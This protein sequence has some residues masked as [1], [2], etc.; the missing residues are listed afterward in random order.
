[1]I[2]KYFFISIYLFL[3]ANKGYAQ[4]ENENIVQE[5]I[6]YTSGNTDWIPSLLNANANPLYNFMIYNGRIFSWNLRGE[7]GSVKIV[8]GIKWH[9]GI[10]QWSGD[11]LFTGMNYIFKKNE[12]HLNGAFSNNGYFNSNNTNILTTENVAQKK[13][14]TFLGNFSNTNKSNNTKNIAMHFN[15]VIAFKNVYSNFAIKLEE[16]PLGILPNGY[17][18]LANVFFS[19]DKK[20]NTNTNIGL[21]VLWNYSDQGRAATTSNEMYALSQ[22]RS[23]S[24]NWGWYHNKPYFP[25]TRQT[26][27]PVITFRYL[28]KWSNRTSLNVNNGIILG[29]EARSNLVWTNTADPRPDY[30]KYMPSY[31]VDTL[32]SNQLR[33]WYLQHPQQLQINFDQMDR[34]NN[35]TSEK[36]SFYIVNQENSSLLLLHGSIQFAHVVKQK[37]NF[38][39][40]IEYALDKVHF[41]NTIKDLLGGQFFFNYNGWMNDDTL[42]F[43]FQNDISQPNKKIKQGEKWGADYTM[44]SF[45]AKPWLQVQ[46][47][48]PVFETGFALGYGFEGIERMGSNQNGL[49]PNSKGKSGF[50]YF[51]TADMKAQLMYKYNGRIYFRS[52]LYAKWLAPKYQSVFIDPAINAYPSPYA[53]QESNYGADLSIFYRAPSFKTTLSIYQKFSFNETENKMFYH[54]A[55]AR[56]VYGVIGQI[57]SINNGVE[58]VIENNLLQSLKMNY[59]ATLSNNFY[60]NN[61]VYAYLDVNNLQTK[62]SG[63][64]QIKNLPKNNGPKL[65]NAIS[66]IYQPVYGFT[67]GVTTLYAQERPVSMN[68]FRRSEW[69]KNKIDPITW[70]QIQRITILDDQFVVNV[71]VSKYFQTKPSKYSQNLF[72]WSISASARN[73]LNTSIPIIAYEQ[74]RFD[75]LR[76]KKEKFVMKYLMDPGASFSIRIQL[77]IQ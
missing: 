51:T 18:K 61:P 50:Q 54:D 45:Q 9:S 37:V 1:M 29:K 7:S 3:I 40:G 38:Q 60:S 75:Y 76:F 27:V 56:F 66:L 49:Y 73:I 77:Q 16:A 15:N 36:R 17:K 53:L 59:A 47:Q 10:A 30:Y 69:V 23:Y 62:E 55:Y 20:A 41:F 13:T 65:V 33:D 24:P 5:E 52:I 28:K 22:Q 43:S 48:G 57:N 6:A 21:S 42:A 11:H 4:V 68:L 71:F 70:S 64:L 58:L 32:L 63:F 12:V 19:I 39:I 35:A 2:F 67:I 46:K 72:R 8:D 74:T 25:S 31:I 34:V 26:N 44:H 14:T